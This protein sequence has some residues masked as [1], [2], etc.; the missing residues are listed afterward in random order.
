M[1]SFLIAMLFTWQGAQE[2][3]PTGEITESTIVRHIVHVDLPNTSSEP[4]ASKPSQT[5]KGSQQP[6][7]EIP[8]GEIFNKESEKLPFYLQP[9][10]GGLDGSDHRRKVRPNA[11]GQRL[12]MD[13]YNKQVRPSV[14]P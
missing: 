12:D 5:I 9:E 2:I 8:Y 1:S 11:A 10:F 6:T 7:T 13:Q 14:G 3:I 4:Q